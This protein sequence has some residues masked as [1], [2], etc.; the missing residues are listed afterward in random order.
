[1]TNIIIIINL[2]L[3]ICVLFFALFVRVILLLEDKYF[4]SLMYYGSALEALS[5]SQFYFLNEKKYLRKKQIVII[6]NLLGG[7][8]NP[9]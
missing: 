4:N 2:C 7:V 6:I 8:R 3:F 5:H 9:C 1:M